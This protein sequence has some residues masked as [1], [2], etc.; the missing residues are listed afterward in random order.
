MKPPVVFKLTV[1]QFKYN[2]ELA[3]MEEP[4]MNYLE[5]TVGGEYDN[6]K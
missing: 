3:C 5:D 4:I 6:I 1:L 2:I